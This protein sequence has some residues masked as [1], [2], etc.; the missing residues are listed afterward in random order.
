MMPIEAMFI[1]F[2]ASSQTQ[3]KIRWNTFTPVTPL[4]ELSLWTLVSRYLEMRQ[5]LWKLQSDA[6]SRHVISGKTSFKEDVDI[7]VKKSAEDT[8]TTK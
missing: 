2:Q 3:T 1:V 7:G 8:A 5:Q 6:E 4:V